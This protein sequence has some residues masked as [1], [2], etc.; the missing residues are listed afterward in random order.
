[1]VAETVRRVSGRGDNSGGLQPYLRKAYRNSSSETFPELLSD[2]H[3]VPSGIG[4]AEISETNVIRTKRLAKSAVVI[5]FIEASFSFPVY[6]DLLDVGATERLTAL[7]EPIA[8][9]QSRRQKHK[10]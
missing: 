10:K 3:L 5:S 6:I 4:S 9:L 7:I 2:T 8:L 1:M